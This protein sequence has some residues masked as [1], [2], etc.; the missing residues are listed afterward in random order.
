MLLSYFLLGIEELGVQLEE[1]FSVL[2]LHKITSGIGLSAEE[3][4]QWFLNDNAKSELKTT[5]SG[6]SP[7][8]ST[9]STSSTAG[10]PSYYQNLSP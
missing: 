10:T 4:V 9:T 8:T 6:T 5:T 3:H 1:P 7:T 2:P